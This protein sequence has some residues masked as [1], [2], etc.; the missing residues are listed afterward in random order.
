MFKQE[1]KTA[2]QIAQKL[3]LPANIDKLFLL[4]STATNIYGSHIYY[5]S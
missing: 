3:N 5:V 1:E 4:V 2:S